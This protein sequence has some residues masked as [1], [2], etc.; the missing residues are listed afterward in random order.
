MPCGS[1]AGHLFWKYRSF[2]PSFGL[3]VSLA[4]AT[5]RARMLRASTR[6]LASRSGL[7]VFFTG[8]R[9]SRNARIHCMVTLRV[10]RVWLPNQ[11]AAEE[12]VDDHPQVAQISQW[13]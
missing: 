2:D 11:T 9:G 12:S 6:A 3:V 8:G 7:S 4:C 13:S 5:M 10:D 1:D